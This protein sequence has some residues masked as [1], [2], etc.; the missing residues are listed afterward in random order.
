MR[1]VLGVMRTVLVT[2]VTCAGIVLAPW[3][4]SA[5]YAQGAKPIS[6]NFGS[7][8][9]GSTWYQY[10]ASMANLMQTAL[11]SG[12]S[13]TVRPYA[14]AFGNIKLIERD[15]K[16]QVAVTFNTDAHWAYTST[17]P[18]KGTDAKA[19]RAL[20]GGLDRNYIAVLV[21]KKLGVNSLADVK[22]RKLP[23]HVV[24]LPHGG[25]AYE[26]TKMILGDYGIT[27]KD[28][29]SW[30]GSWDK[31]NIQTAGNA[32][33]DG[34]ADVWINPAALGH[35]K[36]T[37]LSQTGK[38]KF[39]SL[40]PKI[41]GELHEAGFTPATLPANSFPKQ[42][43]AVN[44]V[45]AT[46]MVIVNKNMPNDLAYALTKAVISHV[47]KLRTDNKGLKTFHAHNAWESSSVGGVPLHPGAIE[48][49]KKAGLMQ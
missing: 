5:V 32:M 11:P 10:A 36:I 17:G 48:Y 19:M 49:F 3:G 18:H 26:V 15:A 14:G 33:Q 42:H 34:R 1:R 16:L 38:V 22:A 23:I 43:E 37:E 13:V 31:V 44:T 24:S 21:S 28:I 29:K 9:V 27:E 7:T 2:S 47:A 6:L 30:G 41:I 12:S 39:L 25:L 40:E 46:T 8:F 35:P 20:F 4:S 45:F